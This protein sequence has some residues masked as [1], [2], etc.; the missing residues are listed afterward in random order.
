MHLMIEPI[1]PQHRRPDRYVYGK[2][3]ISP[4]MVFQR[5]KDY[6]EG[7][8]WEFEEYEHETEEAK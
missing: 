4:D 3:L 6:K 1:K 8:K 5:F 2:G 7:R